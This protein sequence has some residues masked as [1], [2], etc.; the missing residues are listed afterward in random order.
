MR[1]FNGLVQYQMQQYFSTSKFVMPF[2]VL[3]ILLY[4]IYSS[5]PVGVMDSLTVSCVFLFLVMVWVG[6]TACD[7]EDMVSEQ[8]LILRVQSAG[9][10]YVSHAV[11]LFLL[12]MIVSAVAVIFPVLMDLWNQGQ[13]FERPFGAA[14]LA[15]GFTLMCLS[16]FSGASL[17][18]IS[19]PRLN[20]DR[21]TAIIFTFLLAV[22]AVTKTALLNKVPVLAVI[23]WVLPPVS[24]VMAIFA[25]ETYFSVNKYSTAF[26]I[27]LL[28]GMIWTAVK[29]AGLKKKGF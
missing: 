27:L 4:S 7:M 29:I 1:E 22:T 28:S 17:G 18:E 2:A 11:F 21:K 15:G 8:I 24:D 10:Y 13:L 5:K 25:D 12:G 23:L 20:K 19:H 9:K 14:D 26:I 16:G 6:V 3:M